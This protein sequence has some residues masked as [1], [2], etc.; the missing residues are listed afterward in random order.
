[1][2]DGSLIVSLER[3]ES[4]IR[5]VCS[6]GTE[7]TCCHGEHGPACPVGKRAIILLLPQ[8]HRYRSRSASSSS[9]VPTVM[10]TS[11]H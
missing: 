4:S 9:T 11:R 8:G 2:T 1:M 10:A 6:E 3:V 7:R 5:S